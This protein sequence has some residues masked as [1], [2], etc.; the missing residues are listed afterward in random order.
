[1]AYQT[2]TP[3]TG[4]SYRLPQE[5]TEYAAD[6]TTPLRTTRTEY[7][8]PNRAQYEALRIIGLPH[9]R[10]VYDG[11]STGTLMSEVEYVYDDTGN[12]G[13]DPNLP[14]YL[15]ALPS[16]AWQHDAANYDTA[17]AV[18]GNVTRIRR[19]DVKGGANSFVEAQ[20]GYNVT[21]AVTVAR[22]AAGHVS[23]ISYADAFYQ[24]I[25]RTDPNPQNRL[26]TFAYPTTVT[27][28]D[29][30][31]AETWYNYDWKGRPLVTTRP[32]LNPGD[33]NEAPATVVASYAGCG[34][35]GGEVV[36][37]TDEV[38]RQQKV[39]SDPLGWQW[40]AEILNWDGSVYATT[41]NILN[42]LDQPAFVRRYKGT[43]Q[44]G[45]YQETAYTYDG[46]GRLQSGHAPD[47]DAGHSTA[48]AYNPDDTLYSV[49]DGRGEGD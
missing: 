8:I 33:P 20:T 47:Q 38:G 25:N 27:D 4:G 49:T 7:D 11:T 26:K 5:V 30:F 36:T 9:F 18:R 16:P 2:F 17:F 15:Q 19:Y 14:T 45:V 35:A 24:S 40:K 28:P 43:D 22:D 42:V 1:V 13:G 12:V 41:E 32:K 23:S 3:Q 29:G 21:G 6:T 10:K 48:Y 46:Y 34:C 31:T 39:Y 37:L 44:S